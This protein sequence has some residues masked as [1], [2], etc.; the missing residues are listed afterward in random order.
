MVSF[1]YTIFSEKKIKRGGILLFK[2]KKL[3]KGLNYYCHV[4]EKFK[5]MWGLG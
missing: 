3:E 5:F 1:M 4:N 2:I